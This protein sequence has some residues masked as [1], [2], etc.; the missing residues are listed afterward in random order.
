M[1]SF[2]MK[3]KYIIL[4]FLLFSCAIPLN[5][6]EQSH[7][8]INV[9]YN[10]PK[11]YIIGGITVSGTK[12]LDNNVL[13]MLS[14]LSI[15]DKVKIPSDKFT[16]AIR[17]LWEQGLF[18]DIQVSVTNIVDNQ[19]FLN[20]YFKERPRLSYFS[21]SGVKKSEADD[22]REKIHI[23]RGDYVTEN[24]IIKT[25][26]IVRKYYT[27][28]GFLDAQVNILQKGDTAGSNNIGLMI[29]VNKGQRVRIY[30]I[31]IHG[32][33]NLTTEQLK[34]SMKKTKEKSVFNPMENIDDIIYQAT[35]AA[36]HID[37]LEIVNIIQKNTVNNVRFRVF[38]S[39]KFI[40]EDYEE[41]KMNL[42]KKYN[43]MGY[44]DARILRD[45]VSKN[46]DKSINLDIWVEEG[47]KYFFR[48][49]T[50][51]GNTKY[52]DMM[53]NRILK[54]KKGDVY[55]ED[56][57][58][59]ALTYNPNSTDIRSLYM[60]DGYLFFDVNP[61]EINI[62]N[63]SIDLEIRMHEGPQA[64]V[65]KVVIKGN[66]KTNDYV[67][68]RE[69]V[70]RPGQLFSREKL[71][72]SQQKLAQLKYFDAEKITPNVT[73]NPADGTV[74]LEYNVEET[75][76]DQVELSGGWGYGRIIG[77]LGVSF[78]NFSLRNLL[79]KH[80]WKPI[81]AGE[82]QKLSLRFQTYGSGYLSYSASFTEPWLGGRKP[83]ALSLSYFHSLYSNS[84]SRSD[85]NYAYLK[86]DG[87]SIGLGNNLKW[88]DDFFVLYQTINFQ[89]YKTHKYTEI[90]SATSGVYNSISYAVNLSRSSIDA[91]IYPKNGSEVSL[92]L[93]MTPPYSLFRGD[94]DYASMSN[95]ERY[96][97]VEFYKW[98]FKGAWYISLVDKLVLTPRVQFGVLGAYNNQLGITPFERFYLGGD[99]LTGY[100]NMD[101]RELIGMRGYQNNTLTPDYSSSTT[102]GGTVY[103]KYTFE[104]RYPISLNPSATIYGLTFL[105]AG[106]DWLKWQN[107]NPFDVYRSVG[108]GIRVFLPMFGL[109]GLDWGYGLD[110][111]PNISDANGSQF[112]FSI[113]SSID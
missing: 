22:L 92:T 95:N 86:I 69:L 4:L 111:V 6:Q 2:V 71:I 67:A 104:L 14:G 103:S 76:S 82:G 110:A 8:E 21:F 61:V 33:K 44:R 13:I 57:L 53:L 27:D 56:A 85:T 112:H 68:I 37:F 35:S 102:T 64:T 66:T 113:N 70:T 47:H 63:D 91:P 10:N 17:K 54:I 74:D 49:I 81:P 99:G 59:T 90:L 65:N 20:I 83:I 32:N 106:N 45:S 29:A 75:S 89:R 52:T 19:I 55:D 62:E 78:N 100:N 96:K 93:T 46:N 7:R 26:D 1:N 108:F 31:T 50:W 40:Q 58:N 42:L 77:T 23:V 11:D 25:R 87:I 80:A 107:V 39:S 43:S 15:G 38:K 18:E 34:A 51:V 101:G 97:W 98:K 84:Y 72:R 60:D 5:A 12:Y 36:L 48:N 41:D 28:K 9:D 94:L 88:P 24:L 3:L 30:N 109:L 16:T 73:P 79:N 105:E